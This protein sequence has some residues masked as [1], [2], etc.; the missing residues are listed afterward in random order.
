[1]IEDLQSLNS[2]INDFDKGAKSI[3]D[4]L[5]D[6]CDYQQTLDDLNRLL[7]ESNAPNSC[8]SQ[9]CLDMMGCDWARY[10]ESMENDMK[11]L[12]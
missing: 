1:M 9:F 2:S 7:E 11:S 12:S 5:T 6:Y 8:D 3:V 4:A 10:M